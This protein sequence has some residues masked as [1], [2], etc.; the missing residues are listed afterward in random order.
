MPTFRPAPPS[1]YAGRRDTPPSAGHPRSSLRILRGSPGVQMG[2]DMA[3]Y[4]VHQ[5]PMR[6]QDL[7]TGVQ[8]CA[9]RARYRVHR[10]GENGGEGAD[11]APAICH[12]RSKRPIYCDPAPC[13]YRETWVTIGGCSE[14][15]KPRAD[16]QR[17]EQISG[18]IRV[19]ED[20]P[21]PSSV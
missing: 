1:G 16:V 13:K 10:V 9:T 6:G 8:P 3:Y 18:V 7:G 12:P 4:P 19:I 21:S 15:W 14:R 5:T 2:L 11:T 17:R 20:R